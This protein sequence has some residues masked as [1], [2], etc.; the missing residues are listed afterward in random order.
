MSPPDALRTVRNEVSIVRLLS[1]IR[2][3][4]ALRIGNIAL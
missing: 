3:N 4:T 2:E 1:K